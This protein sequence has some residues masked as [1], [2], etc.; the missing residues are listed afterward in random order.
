MGLQLSVSLQ[1]FHLIY[2]TD[3]KGKKLDSHESD[4]TKQKHSDQYFI[5]RF[6]MSWLNKVYWSHSVPSKQREKNQKQNKLCVLNKKLSVISQTEVWPGGKAKN[7]L[8][9]M[10]VPC[11][12]LCNHQRGNS[13]WS[14]KCE[15]STE[16]FTR[17]NAVHLEAE[18]PA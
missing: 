11:L 12:L 14:R 10:S 8:C 13:A 9:G 18:T 6:L 1:R 4:K 15:E 5:K 2:I 17:T 7:S 16:L 3:I